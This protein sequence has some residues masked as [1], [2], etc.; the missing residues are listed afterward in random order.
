LQ[1]KQYIF[2][3]LEQNYKRKLYIVDP[4]IVETYK[5][6]QSPTLR[7]NLNPP[8]EKTDTPPSEKA[9]ENNTSTSNTN[10]IVNK[11]TIDDQKKPEY[12]QEVSGKKEYIV[13][14]GG[15]RGHEDAFAPVYT[16]PIPE[17]KKK[18]RHDI[19]ECM[20]YLKEKL[21]VSTLDGSDESNRKYCRHLMD[22]FVDSKT[23]LPIERIEK[24]KQ[25]IDCAVQDKF[26]RYKITSFRV[27]YNNAV[28]IISNTRYNKNSVLDL[29][30]I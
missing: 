5:Q 24:V 14:G 16:G 30:Q 26:W 1:K 28:Q 2:I 8:S 10:N 4:Q 13:A 9:E 27:L 6:K 23:A 25:I 18:P 7:E 29:S 12:M 11:L 17:N 20:A 15:A 21:K 3:K 19:T 22:K